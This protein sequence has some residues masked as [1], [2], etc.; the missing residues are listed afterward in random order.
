MLKPP[1]LSEKVQAAFIARKIKT[2]NMD[3]I[4]F[5]E[6]KGYA[7]IYNYI[8]PEFNSRGNQYAEV[9]SII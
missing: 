9:H 4:A 1:A 5:M 7:E 3:M 2:K 6:K 8:H